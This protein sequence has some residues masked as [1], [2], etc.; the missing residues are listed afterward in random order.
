MVATGSPT[1]GLHPPMGCNATPFHLYA[2]TSQAGPPGTQTPALRG[3]LPAGTQCAW[4][5]G[6]Q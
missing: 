1:H 4:M 2:P 6:A 5:V 3:E